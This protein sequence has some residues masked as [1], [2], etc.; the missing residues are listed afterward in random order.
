ME[1]QNHQFSALVL[2]VRT[3]SY[4]HIRNGHEL[5]LVLFDE[6]NE[7]GALNFDWLFGS[8]EERNHKIEKIRFSQIAGWL[9]FEVSSSNANAARDENMRKK[10]T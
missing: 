1:K 7:S 2:S 3:M 9:F 8:V 5:Y 10:I 6:P 4:S